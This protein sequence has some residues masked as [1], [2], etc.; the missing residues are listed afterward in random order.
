MDLLHTSLNETQHDCYTHAL[1]HEAKQKY[2]DELQWK[3]SAIHILREEV[4]DLVSSELLGIADMRQL[5]KVAEEGGKEL[6]GTILNKARTKIDGMIPVEQDN[7]VKS[8]IVTSIKYL[9]IEQLRQKIAVI[10]EQCSTDPKG[11]IDSYVGC[12][13]ERYPFVFQ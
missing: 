4:K 13:K 5:C 11:S 10:A 2:D 3:E 1:F 12:L 8:V 9:T 6:V 7:L